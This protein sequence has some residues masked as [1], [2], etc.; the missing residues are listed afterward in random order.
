[1]AEIKKPFS[2]RVQDLV[3]NVE[4]G[5]GLRLVQ[6][7]L[8]TL[9]IIGLMMFFTGKRFAGLKEAE[10][11][12]QAQLGRN[13]MEKHRLVT[14]N[15]RPSSMWF[16][17]EKSSQHNPKMERHPDIVNPPLYPALLAMGFLATRGAF[18]SE[19][20]AGVFTPE[21]WIIVPFGHLCTVLS[22][23]FI[24]LLGRKLFDHRHGFWAMTVFFLSVSIW[25]LSVSGLNISLLVLLGLGSWYWALCAVDRRLEDDTSPRWLLLLLL[26]LVCAVAAVYTRY[27]GVVLAPMVALYL[28]LSLY[29]KGG[30]GWALAY[31]FLFALALTP[32]LLRN[33]MVSGGPLGL[34]PYL[35]LNGTKLFEGDTFERMLAPVLTWERILHSLGGK[36]LT[37]FSQMYDQSIRG[38]GEGLFICF[39]LTSFFFKF[40]RPQ[41]NLFRWCIGAGLLLF[42][43]I[44]P[45][46]GDT[47]QRVV[48]LFWPAAITYGL[49]FFFILLQRLQ[50][51]L[52]ILNQGMTLLFV[53]LAA[54]PLIVALAPARI[55]PP[56]PPY[57]PP[58]IKHVCNLV[59]SDELLCTDMPWATAWYGNRDSLQLPMN[60]DEFYAVNDHTR[61]VSGLY[62]TTLTR[63]RQFVHEL[64]TG[65]YRSWFPLLEGRIPGDFPLNQGFPLNN[66]DQ[67]FLTDR[68]RWG[69]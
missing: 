29:K 23:V 6:A 37:N 9:F 51:R 15:I 1:M 59:H 54:V 19:H 62:F 24:Y 44:A 41:V 69:E 14:Q 66:M 33:M 31:L 56:Y 68:T 2:V 27:I 47:T 16:L 20:I 7:L 46:F 60:I 50:F 25:N 40:S 13:L 43:L 49:A 3:Y 26:S 64:L 5:L 21:Q 36:W 67:L 53:L 12:D 63:D 8:Y 30:W 34:A 32:W 42:L 22:G 38:L 18:A 17:I 57:Y 65:S 11:M 61:H 35:A 58:F 48:V 45:F 28:G 10:A 39:F 55:G 4:V 52:R